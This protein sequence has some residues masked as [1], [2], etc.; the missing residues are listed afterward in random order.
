MEPSGKHAVLSPLH[1]RKPLIL[2]GFPAFIGYCHPVHRIAVTYG[3]RKFRFSLYFR[4]FWR[5]QTFDCGIAP[6]S[7]RDS[8]CL[9]LI[10]TKL[11][12]F[13]TFATLFFPW[14]CARIQPRVIFIY[15]PLPLICSSPRHL[16]TVPFRI[17]ASPEPPRLK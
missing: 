3:T 10:C 12:F 6:E 15:T 7:S 5:F 1:A 13:H 2:L 8:S 14:Y 11:S 16:S 9:W 4:H 17:S